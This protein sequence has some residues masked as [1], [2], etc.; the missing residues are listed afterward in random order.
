MTKGLVSVVVPVYKVEKY[1]D[2]CLKSIVSQSYENLEI[3]LVDDGSPDRCPEICD[4]WAQKDGRIKVFHQENQGLS[5]ARNVG[6]AHATG[7]YICFFDSDDFVDSETVRHAY[8]VAEKENTDLVIFGISFVNEAGEERGREIPCT[9]RWVYVGDQ[10]REEL[11]PELVGKNPRTGKSAQVMLSAWRVLF[12]MELIR[13]TNWKFVSEKE[14]ISEDVYSLLALYKNVDKVAILSEPLYCYRVNE[15]SVSRSYRPDRFAKNR[16]FYLQCVALCKECGYS[17][18]VKRRCYEPYLA[19][20][21]ATLKQAVVYYGNYGKAIAELRTMINDPVF[22]S[23]LT[24]KKKDRDGFNK[25]LF[26]WAAR[27][28]LYFLCYFLLAAKVR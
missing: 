7:Q 19:N 8:D 20:V 2:H 18:E 4:S 25:K 17:D 22:Q 15:Q 28:K 13:R 10:V 23:V 9:Q 1:L 21:F 12:S 3:I 26:Y 11:L 24:E 16:Q 27:N 5:A 6:I 14:V